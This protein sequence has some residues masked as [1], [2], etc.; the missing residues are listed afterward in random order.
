MREKFLGL[1]KGVNLSCNLKNS[2][3]L[4]MEFCQSTHNLLGCPHNPLCIEAWPVSEGKGFCYVIYL[5]HAITSLAQ[6][7][8]RSMSV[9]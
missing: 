6:V 3:C 1:Y 2:Q 5:H 9:V 4:Y 8:T 7:F